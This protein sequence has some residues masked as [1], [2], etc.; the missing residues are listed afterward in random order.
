MARS[1][2][3]ERADTIIVGTDGSESAVRAVREASW[4]ARSTGSKLLIVSAFSDLHPYREHIESSARENLVNLGEVADQLLMRA[5]AEA[6]GD[7]V[8]IETASREGDPAEV[9]SAIAT[10]E[11]ARLVI[12]GDRGLTGVGRFLLGSVSQKLSHHAPCSVLI[13][14]GSEQHRSA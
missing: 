5:S 9:L 3:G 11:N 7:D 10:E 13:V 8:E 1:E 4:L 6:D 12:V 14:R 2:Q